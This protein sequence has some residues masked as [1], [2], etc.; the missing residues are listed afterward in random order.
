MDKV[1]FTQPFNGLVGIHQIPPNGAAYYKKMVEL[2]ATGT[3]MTCNFK[4][5]EKWQVQVRLQES[6]DGMLRVDGFDGYS[7]MA[8]VNNSMFYVKDENNGLRRALCP[9]PG[10]T[11]DPLPDEVWYCKNHLNSI[12]KEIIKPDIPCLP[13]NMNKLESLSAPSD[14]HLKIHA[15]Q[16]AINVDTSS[17]DS[18]VVVSSCVSIHNKNKT[19]TSQKNVLKI[20]EQPMRKKALDFSPRKYATRLQIKRESSSCSEIENTITSRRITTKR[21][22]DKKKLIKRPRYSSSSSDEFTIVD[23]K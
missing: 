15:N 11:G 4:F 17:P 18:P 13:A 12:D 14:S 22:T 3:Q 20:I 2:K 16:R 5:E 8:G 1:R 9:Y 6:P 7:L 19:K 21:I 10:C 23:F